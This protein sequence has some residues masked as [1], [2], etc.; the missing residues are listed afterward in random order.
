MT[1]PAEDRLS[2]LL[3][4]RGSGKTL[5]PSEVARD[6]AGPGGDWRLSM[7]AV[8]EAVDALLSEG[9]IT[10]SWKG[11]PL[12]RRDGPYRIGTPR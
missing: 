2:A 5:C 8:H 9:R 1:V 12:P 4:G 6:L 7:G 11:K 3:H 10:L